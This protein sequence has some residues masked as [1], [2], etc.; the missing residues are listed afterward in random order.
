RRDCLV[1]FDRQVFVDQRWMDQA[2]ALFP[3]G[4]IVDPGC[5]VA[6]WNLHERE[7]R[8]V[9]DDLMIG[10]V[11]LRFFHFS[12]LEPERP[13]VI[14]KYVVDKP[15]VVLSEYPEAAALCDWYL[16]QLAGASAP[17]AP[18]Y[19]FDRLPDGTRMTALMRTVYRD[20]ILR[21]DEGLGELPPPVFGEGADARTIQRWFLEPLEP[22]ARIGRLLEG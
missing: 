1:A 3:C 14:S 22:G 15:R 10:D 17:D 19:A 11:P 20:A 7:L 8:R 13:W 5:N 2:P 18:W 9:G 21:A 12:G 4:V 16:E 6:Y